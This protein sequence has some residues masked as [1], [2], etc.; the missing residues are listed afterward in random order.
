MTSSMACSRVND[1]GLMGVSISAD[2]LA[3][4]GLTSRWS[5]A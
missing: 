4:M 2:Q 5:R 3:V 1:E